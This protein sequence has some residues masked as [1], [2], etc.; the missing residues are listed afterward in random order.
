MK[1]KG[2]IELLKK[3][4]GA[5][6][7]DELPPEERIIVYYSDEPRPP[8]VDEQG[9]RRIVIEYDPIFRGI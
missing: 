6:K 3:R 7:P 2:E 4:S 1:H 9:R 8:E 5:G